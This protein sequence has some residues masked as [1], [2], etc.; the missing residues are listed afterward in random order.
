MPGPINPITLPIQDLEATGGVPQDYPYGAVVAPDVRAIN[1]LWNAATGNAELQRTMGACHTVQLKTAAV[2]IW[3]PAAGKKFRLM[4]YSILLS[5]DATLA[6]AGETLLTLLD[7]ATAI[8]LAYNFYV[9]LTAL[10]TNFSGSHIGVNLPPNG[11]LSVA[12][13]NPLKATLGTYLATG[14]FSINVWG[15]EE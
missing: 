12:A 3:T 4:G 7:N 9:P 5:D 2:T 1:L 13:N 15:S 6:A 11:Y 10:D 14:S 8:G